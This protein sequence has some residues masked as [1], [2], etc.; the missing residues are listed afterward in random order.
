MDLSEQEIIQAMTE[1][2]YISQKFW[3]ITLSSLKLSVKCNLIALAFKIREILMV[4]GVIQ[5]T[6]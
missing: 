4:D 2:R 6:T 1:E 3:Q 5:D